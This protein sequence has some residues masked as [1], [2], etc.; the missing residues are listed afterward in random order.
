SITESCSTFTV[1]A[2]SIKQMP[3]PYSVYAYATFLR[4]LIVFLH[5]SVVFIAMALIF[6]VHVTL[7]TLLI[8]PALVALCFT[9]SWVSILFGVFAARFRDI[10]QVVTSLLAVSMFVTPI[11]WKPSQLG[12]SFKAK[13][14][15]GVNPLAHYVAIMRAPLLGQS[16]GLFNWEFVIVFSILGWMFS[17]YILGRYYK[18][19]AFWL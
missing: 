9:V 7:N 10:Q 16:P 11:F 19:I 18:H 8:F 17:M 4:G 1:A 5:H 3:M 15:M 13:L 2:G 12:A 14:I 6:H